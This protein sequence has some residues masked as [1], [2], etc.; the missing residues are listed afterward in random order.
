MPD[1]KKIT[2]V[3]RQA[4]ATAEAA[5][6]Q[7]G[8]RIQH[9]VQKRRVRRIVRETA[10]AAAAAGAAAATGALI[11]EV[12]RRVRR[13]QVA[14]EEPAEVLGFTVHLNKSP[15]QAIDA[16]TTALK[17]EGFGVLTRIDVQATLKEKLNRDFRPYTILGACNPPLAHRAL[18]HRTEAGLLLPCNVTV[19]ASSIGGSEIRIGNPDAFLGRGTLGRDPV[20]RE[21]AKEARERLERVAAALG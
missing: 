6:R 17:V 3:V 4:A 10:E 11:G 13:R 18:S 8:D 20:L 5:V 21:V 1:T 12:A 2:R 19:E 7:A 15:E 9:A 14:G 16:V